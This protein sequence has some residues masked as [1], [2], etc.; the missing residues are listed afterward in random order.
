MPKM[1]L[2]DRGMLLSDSPSTPQHVGMI[3]TFELPGGAPGTYV[4]DLVASMRAVR[5]FAPPFNYRQPA[6]GP[7]GAAW[8]ELANDAIDLDYHLRH[9]AL[10]A[11][12]G[13]RELGVLVSHLH[14]RPLD[15]SRPLW[16]LTV[17]EGL[18]ER[19][20]GL[21]FKVHHAVLDG[22]GGAIR[23]RQMLTTDSADLGVRPLWSI[24]PKAR[25]RE[26]GATSD[27]V[28]R[29]GQAARDAATIATGLGRLALSDAVDRWNPPADRAV[30]YANPRAP[31]NARVGQER[32]VATQSFE[33][34]DLEMVAAATS[35]TLNDVFLTMVGGGLRRYLLEINALPERTL[36]AGTPVNVRVEGDDHSTNA[37]TMTVMSLGTDIDDARERLTVVNR[38]SVAA[39]ARLRRL[40]KPVIPLSFATFMGPFMATQL[41]GLGGRTTPPYNIVLSNIAG[42]RQVSYMAGSRLEAIYPAAF[43]YHGVGLFVAVY[44]TGGR[45]NVGFTGDRDLLPHLQHL[46]LYTGE[47]L[48]RLQAAVGAASS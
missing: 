6:L 41:V 32:R 39:K 15:H 9:V 31:M 37:F 4:A 33:L 5:E 3:A 42:P 29:A 35:T 27:V 13:E 2:V 22:H 25:A 20:W 45:F 23:V 17:I 26:S 43:A 18:S 19:R 8:T 46:A 7:F 40:P 14:S 16:E 1:E 12:A 11:P 44:T 34:G 30:P 48:T 21:Y 47:E 28:R 36:T 38:S 24:G 10:P